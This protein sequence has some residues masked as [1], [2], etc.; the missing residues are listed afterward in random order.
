ML[1]TRPCAIWCGH[2][3]PPFECWAKRDSTCKDFYCDTSGFTAGLAP[4]PWPID[5]GCRRCAIEHSAQQIVLQDYIH[6]VQEA[7]T[8]R[9]RLTQ[10]IEELL[11][12]W[13]MAPVVL[14]LV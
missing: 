7:E 6:A 2:V 5:A 12:N 4:G 13:S 3:R 14:A 9:D 8:R 11:P 10:Q 1:R